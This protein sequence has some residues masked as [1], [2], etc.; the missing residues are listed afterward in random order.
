MATQH[1]GPA[2]ASHSEPGPSSRGGLYAWYVVGVLIVAY[3]MAFLDRQIM[4]LL[5]G[6]IKADLGISDI[7]IGLL[8]GLAFAIFYSLCILPAGWM[9]D[10]F[11]PRNI[12]AIGLAGWCVM[13]FAC[14]LANSFGTL[15][16]ARMGVGIGEAVLGPAAFSIIAGLFTKER[17]PLAISVYSVG[18]SIG[19]GLAYLFGAMATHIA[20]PAAEMFPILAGMRDWQVAFIMVSLP[21]IPILLLLLTIR[22]PKRAAPRSAGN[23]DIAAPPIAAFLWDRTRFFVLY[24]AGIGLL[25]TVSYANMAWIPTMFNRI[26]GWETARTAQYLGIMMLTFGTAGVLGGGLVAMRVSRRYRDATLRVAFWSALA[27]V[28]ICALAALVPNPWISLVLYAPFTFI[29][30]SFVSLG[31]TSIQLITPDALR[32]RINGIALMFVTIIGV[33]VGPVFVATMTER[34]FGGPMMISWGLG[35]GAALLALGSAVLIYLSLSHYRAALAS[36]DDGGSPNVRGFPA[37]G[38][39]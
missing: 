32:G 27:L 28:P 33:S 3:I 18:G 16:A 13:T 34:V 6:P 4:S 8:Q 29:S 14:G 20:G 39:S 38:R 21:G 37:G 7:Q 25:T 30:T 23:A 22:Q 10:R 24:C 26:Y 17:L 12:L 19:A 11:S 2:P 36:V 35:I 15:F 9:V 5:V 1:V 31:P